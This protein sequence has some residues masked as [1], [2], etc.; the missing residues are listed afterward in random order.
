MADESLK[1]LNDNEEKKEVISKNFI[2]REIDKDLAEDLL[3]GG[4]H[5]K[6]AVAADRVADARM[7]DHLARE[8]AHVS[9]G[10]GH[11][12]DAALE[13]GVQHARVF[14]RD[15]L[16]GREEGAVHV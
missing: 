9:A 4:I 7:G 15:G 12:L 5:D 10:A 3:R 14:R 2:E 13:G 11:E 8:V 16:L 1:N 6:G